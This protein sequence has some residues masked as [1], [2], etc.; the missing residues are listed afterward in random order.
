MITP[1][2]AQE[3]NG[4]LHLQLEGN[5]NSCAVELT[6]KMAKST[7]SGKGNIF[8]NT[9]KVQGVAHDSATTLLSLLADDILPVEKLYMIGEKGFDLGGGQVR[10]I[11]R[12]PRKARCGGCKKKTQKLQPILQ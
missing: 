3:R 1:I 12:P 6:V 2:I 10:V 4:H 9:E 11:L 5:V 7:Y 8:I